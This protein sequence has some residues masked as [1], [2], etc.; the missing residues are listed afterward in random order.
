MAHGVD[1]IPSQVNDD[2][3]GNDDNS[4]SQRDRQ[5]DKNH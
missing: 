1:D 5:H 3:D 2:A 4:Q